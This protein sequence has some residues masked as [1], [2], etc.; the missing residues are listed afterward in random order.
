MDETRITAKM[1]RRHFKGMLDNFPDLPSRLKREPDTSGEVDTIHNAQKSHASTA[2][3]ETVTKFSGPFSIESILKKDTRPRSCA[4]PNLLHIIPSTL[5]RYS[6]DFKHARTGSGMKRKSGLEEH[7]CGPAEN[8]NELR[9][10]VYVAANAPFSNRGPSALSTQEIPSLPGYHQIFRPMKRLRMCPDLPDTMFPRQVAASQF[11]RSEAF[12]CDHV[13]HPMNVYHLS[14]WKLGL[15]NTAAKTAHFRH[16]IAVCSILWLPYLLFFK[17]IYFFTWRFMIGILAGT[18][19]KEH[20]FRFR[21]SRTTYFFMRWKLHYQ[22]HSLKVKMKFWKI[23]SF[24]C[25]SCFCRPSAYFNLELHHRLTD[26][27]YRSGNSEKHD[28][29]FGKM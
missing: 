25:V 1:I 18:I 11:H 17:N 21:F 10:N 23:L 20:E 14:H 27:R 8:T 24:P 13:H 6:Q 15:W 2:Q 3:K 22:W 4:K 9:R 28:N 12:A 7:I 26:W 16:I 19:H 29:V 5:E